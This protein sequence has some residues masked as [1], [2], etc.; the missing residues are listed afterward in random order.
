M[1]GNKKLQL[2]KSI[3]FENNNHTILEGTKVKINVIKIER[4]PDYKKLSDKYKTFIKENRGKI[5][6]V[7]Y[8]EDKKDKPKL[9]CL[10]EDPTP[11]KWLFWVGDLIVVQE[12]KEEGI[13]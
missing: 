2:L 10:K 12:K 5:F 6:T 11:I 8:D 13:D 3:E 9:V 7:E 1:K 4:R